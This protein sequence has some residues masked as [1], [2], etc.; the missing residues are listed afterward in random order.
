MKTYSI[1]EVLQAECTL[2][3]MACKFCGSMEVTFLQ[4]L[5]DASCGT[6]GK[7]QIEDAP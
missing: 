4:Y 5:N 6:C 7:W 2:E 3:P 1:E